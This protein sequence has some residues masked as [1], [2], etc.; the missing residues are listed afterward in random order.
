A[1]PTRSAISLQS[2]DGLRRLLFQCRSRLHPPSC[3]AISRTSKVPPSYGA[4]FSHSRASSSERTCQ[5]QYPAT[6]SLVSAHGPSMTVR[7]LPSNRTRLPC[8][9]GERRPAPRTTPALTSSSLNFWYSAIASGVGGVAVSLCPPSF[10]STI[11][12]I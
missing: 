3:W 7:F 5:S 6:S 11:T 10:A 4:R 2:R 12:R 1:G 8:E 9:L